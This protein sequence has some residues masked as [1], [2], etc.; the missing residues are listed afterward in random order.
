MRKQE[1][2]KFYNFTTPAV[3][4][5]VASQGIP[6]KITSGPH[7]STLATPP[8]ASYAQVATNVLLPSEL[9]KANKVNLNQIQVTPIIGSIVALA[10]DP[11]VTSVVNPLLKMLNPHTQ[12][13]LVAYDLN[14]KQKFLGG[15]LLMVTDSFRRDG[16][17][18]TAS[19]NKVHAMAGTCAPNLPGYAAAPKAMGV[20]VQGNAKSVDARV[21]TVKK[22]MKKELGC[23]STTTPGA[24]SQVLPTATQ[25][26]LPTKVANIEP[27]LPSRQGKSTMIVAEIPGVR[28]LASFPYGQQMSFSNG[29]KQSIVVNSPCQEVIPT[30][31]DHQITDSMGLVVDL[32]NGQMT[33]E[34]PRQLFEATSGQGKRQSAAAAAPQTQQE[35][36]LTTLALPSRTPLQ[37]LQQMVENTG[38]VS[39]LIYFKF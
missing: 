25:L 29:M 26:Q 39:V 3:N 8:I 20:Y 36:P 19:V 38:N 34:L 9:G 30:Q 17:V 22:I 1:P 2:I 27:N 13:A 12:N 32:S 16:D 11:C 10:T 15:D 37:C 14:R 21:T 5:Y 23:A 7:P 6:S 4:A 33:G 18:S 35:T 24:S 31:A 28:N